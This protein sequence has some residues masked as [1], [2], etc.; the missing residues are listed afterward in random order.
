MSDFYKNLDGVQTILQSESSNL[1]DLAS[2]SGR[3][4]FTFY[5]GADLTGLDLSGQDLTGLNFERANLRSSNLDHVTYDMGAFNGSILNT[6][7]SSLL[8]QFD[9]Y[10]TDILLPQMERIS[11]HAQIRPETIEHCF[12]VTNMSYR[13]FSVDSSLN[14]DTLRRARRGDVISHSSLKKIAY[15]M[16]ELMKRTFYTSG[17]LSNAKLQPMVK[18]LSLQS[19]GGTFRYVGRREIVRMT[20]LLS[21]TIPRPTTQDLLDNSI[22]Y[23]K[24]RPETLAWLYDFYQD[25]DFQEAFT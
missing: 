23:W 20:E 10:L 24:S 13:Q 8:D 17:S 4:P 7:Y 16:N 18:F 22:N 12:F 6:N 21:M 14:L 3:D 11:L 1:R 5:R 15:T 25:V 2:L 19:N 9:S